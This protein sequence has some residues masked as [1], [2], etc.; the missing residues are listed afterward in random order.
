[1]SARALWLDEGPGEI[2]GVVSLADAPERLIIRRAGEAPTQQLGARLIARVRQVLGAQAL[3]FLDL[4]EGPDAALNLSKDIGPIREGAFV[5]VEIRAEA[6]FGKAALARWLGPAEGPA[7]LVAPAPGVDERL[8]QFGGEVQIAR[9]EG[10]REMADLA[11]EEV[12]ERCFRLAG[13]G[14]LWIEPTRALTAVDVDSGARGGGGQDAKRAARA[15]NLAAIAEAARVLRLKG[16]G[17][18]VAIDLVG[19]G[20]D[21]PALLAAARSAFAPDN[22]GVAIA[23]IS[24]FGTLQLTI[25]RRA[26]PAIDI[27]TSG[28]A[29][30]APLTLGLSLARAL[31]REARRDGGGR[32][33]GRASPAVAEAAAPAVAELARAMGGRVSVMAEAGRSDSSFEVAP[34]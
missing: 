8:R 1:M 27:L 5:E 2:R 34:A 13:G 23:P 12:L 29:A 33:V 30:A 4:A 3:A 19:R 26:R 32:F 7:R 6:R 22:P 11:Q 18:L 15:L 21:A 28:A 17:G 20:H 16:L 10:A 24:R 14:V 9:G 25:P 31:E